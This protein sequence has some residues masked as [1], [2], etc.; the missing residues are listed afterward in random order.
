ML[1]PRQQDCVRRLVKARIKKRTNLVQFIIRWALR[2][3]LLARDYANTP[4]GQF[5]FDNQTVLITDYKDFG[6]LVLCKIKS[7]ERCS[8]TGHTCTNA[9]RSLVILEKPLDKQLTSPTLSA[10]SQATKLREIGDLVNLRTQFREEFPGARGHRPPRTR[11][12]HPD[13]RTV[14]TTTGRAERERPLER[15]LRNAED[16]LD[17]VEAQVEPG[18]EEGNPF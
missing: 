7:C 13:R 18:T 16:A 9:R 11:P 14:R 10:A 2:R 8:L 3:G 5:C 4:R 17:R 1:K 15:E 12:D 6:Q